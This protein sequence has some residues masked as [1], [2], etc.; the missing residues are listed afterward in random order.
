MN[1]LSQPNVLLELAKIMRQVYSIATLR[2]TMRP[3]PKDYDCV[4]DVKCT[5][6]M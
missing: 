2:T 6:N 1:E 3:Y 5:V 4:Y